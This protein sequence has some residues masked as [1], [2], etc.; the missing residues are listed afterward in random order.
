MPQFPAV[1]DVSAVDGSNG[2]RIGGS[3]IDA[4]I[5]GDVNGDGFDDLVVLTR[6]SS[7]YVVFGK[8][9]G[10]TPEIA[11]SNLDGGDGFKLGL[12]PGQYYYLGAA[13][14]AG[15]VNGDRIADFILS[16]P[17]YG[18]PQFSGAAYVVFGRATGF[19]SNFNLSG[20]DGSN[21]FAIDGVGAF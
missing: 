12:P 8:A 19:G 10:S 1:I 16:D 7:A 21:G 3:I 4:S 14:P 13:A 18:A 11:L 6:Q 15:D 20:L 17:W 9:A 5:V 2:F